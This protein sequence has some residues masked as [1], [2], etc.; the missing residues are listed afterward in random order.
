MVGPFEVS[1]TTTKNYSTSR[2][3]IP[4]IVT[5]KWFSIFELLSWVQARLSLPRPSTSSRPRKDTI[6]GSAA[7]DCHLITFSNDGR[8]MVLVMVLHPLVTTDYISFS[9]NREL[10]NCDFETVS[11]PSWRKQK[12]DN[13][14]ETDWLIDWLD[15]WLWPTKAE[16]K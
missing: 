15:W 9:E 8:D 6:A 13:V 2:A 5:C 1:T 11:W 10:A 7:L 3:Y 16:S 14:A 12:T 4:S